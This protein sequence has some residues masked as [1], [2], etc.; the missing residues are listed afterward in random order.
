MKKITA[1]LILT[2]LLV[3]LIAGCN[4]NNTTTT[5][6]PTTEAPTTEAPTTETPTT[7]PP[8]EPNPSSEGLAFEMN[9]D[10]KSYAV[11]GIGECKDT[12]MERISRMLDATSESGV[13]LCHENEKGIYGDIAPRCLELA[14]EFGELKL[15]FD[16]A[17][18]V[19]SGQDT[20]EAWELLHDYVYYMHIKDAL[21]S[22]KTVVPAGC[23]DGKIKEVLSHLKEKN[24][25]G[26]LS[27]E[28]HLA[29][30]VGLSQLE[31][32]HKSENETSNNL[33][34]FHIAHD[35]LNKILEE[36]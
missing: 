9:S 14:R 34:K 3:S 8:V 22:D 19:Q 33:D 25:E 31:G 21:S 36:I 17:N 2:M 4:D 13:L 18:F 15:V 30:F 5:E 6:T 12:V 11:V 35:A 29:S 24:Y 32:G 1:L 23:G 28:P 26:F 27:L 10:C 16:P 20:K 7:T